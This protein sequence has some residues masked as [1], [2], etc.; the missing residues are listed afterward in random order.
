MEGSKSRSREFNRVVTGFPLSYWRSSVA[1]FER[2]LKDFISYKFKFDCLVI[3][4][5]MRESKVLE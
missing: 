3:G 4:Q 5:G 2:N 1:R